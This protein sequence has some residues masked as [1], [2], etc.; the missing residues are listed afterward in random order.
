M[1]KKVFSN[2]EKMI[3]HY[4]MIY[5]L[6]YIYILRLIQNLRICDANFDRSLCWRR[7]EVNT[8]AQRKCPFTFC[9]NI[10]GCQQ[11]AR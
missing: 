7:T 5:H 6:S 2:I 4:K 3:Y 8:T 11:I 1:K 9:M 10:N